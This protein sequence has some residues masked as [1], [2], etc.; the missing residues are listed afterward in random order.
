[1]A[2]CLRMS[3]AQ[4]SRRQ[5]YWEV[6]RKHRTLS[7]EFNK[8]WTEKCTNRKSLPVLSELYLI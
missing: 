3:L 6:V 7:L 2:K 4:F 8:M 5:T 1:M